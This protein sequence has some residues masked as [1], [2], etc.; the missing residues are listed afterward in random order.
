MAAL[1]K[2]CAQWERN[3]SYEDFLAAAS[4]LDRG[5]SQ[6]E[7]RCVKLRNR[8]VVLRLRRDY[9]VVLIIQLFVLELQHRTNILY[10]NLHPYYKYVP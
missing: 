9:S 3:A 7:V 8:F 6:L 1:W 2:F 5:R 4:E 10:S